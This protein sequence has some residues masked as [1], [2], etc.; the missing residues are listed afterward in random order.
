MGEGGTGV[1]GA[2]AAVEEVDDDDIPLSEIAP[3]RAGPR[4]ADEP[5]GKKPAIH[6]DSG[7]EP[8]PAPATGQKRRPDTQ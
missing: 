1:A 8:I 5:P 3:K 4:A 7:A 2:P 6:K